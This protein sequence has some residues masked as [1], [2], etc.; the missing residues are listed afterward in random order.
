[1]CV[2]GQRGGRVRAQPIL[3]P[4]L[5]AQYQTQLPDKTMLAA[6]LHEFY[7]LN[8]VDA[9]HEANADGALAP[10]HGTA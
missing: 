2:Q 9:S 5:V 4:A 7:V 1:M 6:K 10:E 3:S 8:A